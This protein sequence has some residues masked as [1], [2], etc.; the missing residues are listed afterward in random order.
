ME[1]FMGSGTIHSGQWKNHLSA[2]CGERIEKQLTGI[3]GARK[4]DISNKSICPFP[5]FSLYPF[6]DRYLKCHL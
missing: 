5:F 6:A 3:R 1:F 4:G 2:S